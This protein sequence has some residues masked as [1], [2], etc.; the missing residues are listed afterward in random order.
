[1]ELKTARL[2]GFILSM[3]FWRFF[4]KSSRD[5]GWYFIS[6]WV[7]LKNSHS[8]E[9]G[10]SFLQ[11]EENLLT[12]WLEVIFRIIPIVKTRHPAYLKGTKNSIRLNPE[13]TCMNI[14]TL[15]RKTDSFLKK[16]MRRWSI[17]FL[18]ASFG[19]IFI[20]FG[21][22]KPLRLSPAEGI[23]LIT[24]DFLPLFDPEEWL[25]IIGWMEV[26][27]G[28]LFLFRRTTKIAIGLLYLQ[29]AGTFMPLF[30]YPDVTFENGWI[31]QPTLEGQYII[32]NLMIIG[33]ALVIGGVT[34]TDHL[35]A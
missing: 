33:A 9:A 12:G 6:A 34:Y 8:A 17:P 31:L 30:L 24:V 26:A 29:M 18:R 28:C 13:I 1:M 32:K 3:N 15:Y 4:I 19:I 22:L 14:T 2:A 20:W 21:I 5:I 23:L 7:L 11:G 10:K 16:V 25:H 35:K 27:I